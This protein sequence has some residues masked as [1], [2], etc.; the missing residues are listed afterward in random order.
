V[1]LNQAQLQALV[2]MAAEAKANI[3][4]TNIPEVIANFYEAIVSRS[5]ATYNIYRDGPN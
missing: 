1:L 5:Y 3:K 4:R 2:A